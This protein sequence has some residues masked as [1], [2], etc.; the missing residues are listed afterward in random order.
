MTAPR[1][2]PRGAL[3]LLRLGDRVV[4]G[5]R[6]QLRHLADAALAAGRQ[7]EREQRDLDLLLPRDGIADR[8]GELGL[9]GADVAGEDD[10]RR[11]A[12]D[13]VE[14]SVRAGMMLA[15]P[16]LPARPG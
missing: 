1:A 4:E 10:Q 11:A 3:S 15:W 14:Q 12:Q 9:A 8:L 2:R 16:T 6:K 13:R 5:C 7:A